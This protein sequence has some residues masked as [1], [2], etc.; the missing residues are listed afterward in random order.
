LTCS[1]SSFSRS[2]TAFI[3]W[4]RRCRCSGALLEVLQVLLE[5][6]MGLLVAVVPSSTAPGGVPAASPEKTLEP[7][8][9]LE[10]GCSDAVRVTS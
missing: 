7:S 9:V 2:W 1:K 10:E 3:L 4:M 5:R 6:L 8:E